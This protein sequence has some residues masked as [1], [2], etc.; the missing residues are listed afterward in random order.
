MAFDPMTLARA[1]RAL[2]QLCRTHL[3]DPNVSLIDV[4]LKNYAEHFDPERLAIRV[5]VG[6]KLT[7]AQLE[8]TTLGR[9]TRAVPPTINGFE[10]DVIEGRYRPHWWWSGWGERRA[11]DLRRRRRDPLIGGISIAASSVR[12]AGTLGGVV[13]DRASG[14]PMLLSNWHVLAGRWTARP[15]QAI[16]QP[17][18]SD[19]A[20][21]ADLVGRLARHAMGAFLDA[22][23]AEVGDERAW[24]LAQHEMGTVRGRTRPV[25]GMRVAKSGRTTG[26]TAGVITGVSGVTTMQY[27]GLTRQIRHVV[28]IEPTAAVI[29]EPGDSGSLYVETTSRAC[30]ALHFAG[31]N[32]PERA[33]ALDIDAVADALGVEFARA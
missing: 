27:D 8:S 17:A 33:L 29:S 11:T 25:P 18:A 19:G 15:G 12:G 23:V 20:S 6:R 13:F 4:G 22:A 24:S 30:A 1:R 16:Y 31:S 26:V 9:S 28:T 5:H 32:L 21:A 2:A 10:T 14:L 3:Y 7:P